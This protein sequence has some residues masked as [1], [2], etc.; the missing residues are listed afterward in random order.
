MEEDLRTKHAD[1]LKDPEGPLNHYNV[2]YP[3]DP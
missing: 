2:I 1:I 3:D